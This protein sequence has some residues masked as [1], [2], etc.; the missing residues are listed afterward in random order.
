MAIRE[1]ILEKPVKRGPRFITNETSDSPEPGSYSWDK[2]YPI[3]WLAQRY[4]DT[5]GRTIF[6]VYEEIK[7]DTG[8]SFDQTRELSHKAIS[9]RFILPI[10][11]E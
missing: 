2:D 3:W 11:R 1:F 5:P 7:D 8:M 9:K 10:T 6:E 4:G